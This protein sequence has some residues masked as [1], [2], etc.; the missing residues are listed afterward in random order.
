MYWP[1]AMG[2]A[3]EGIDSATFLTPSERRDIF[4]DNAAGLLR[5]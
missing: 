1:E 4:D 2:M 5:L 3:V